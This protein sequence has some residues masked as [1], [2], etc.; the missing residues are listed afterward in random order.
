M[1]KNA[2]DPA[3][4]LKALCELSTKQLVTLTE[5]LRDEL[6]RRSRSVLDVFAARQYRQA[7]EAMS[8]AHARMKLIRLR[9]REVELGVRI[10]E[11]SEAPSAA[12]HEAAPPSTPPRD[13]ASE[14]S[15]PLCERCKVDMGH[16]GQCFPPPGPEVEAGP[17]SSTSTDAR[18]SADAAGG[19][20][21]AEGAD[22]EGGAEGDERTKSSAPRAWDLAPHLAVLKGGAA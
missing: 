10:S 14:S 11:P 2:A 15:L 22:G 1:D 21:R 3:A 5:G 13:G 20:A 18:R 19:A 6:M 12:Q 16:E 4:T 9:E 17:Q 7:A 8:A